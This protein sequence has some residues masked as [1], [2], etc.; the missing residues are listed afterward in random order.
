MH[1]V[2]IILVELTIPVFNQLAN[3][4]LAIEELLNSKTLYQ[5]FAIFLTVGVLS[6]IYPALVLSGFQPVLVLKGLVEAPGKNFNLRKVLVVLQFSVSMALIIG[7]IVV[8]YQLNF[9]Q[10]KELN[11]IRQLSLYS[12][13]I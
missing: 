1:L 2:A 3:G 4:A 11:W 13:P 6:G 7:T 12:S 10:N 9:L 5:A 8:Y